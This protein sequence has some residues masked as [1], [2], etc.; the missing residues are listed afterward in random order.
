[1]LRATTD[2]RLTVPCIDAVCVNVSRT[3]CSRA[4]DRS[5]SHRPP[6]THPQDERV[7]CHVLFVPAPPTLPPAT[8]A[9]AFQ[10][11]PPL[12]PFRHQPREQPKSPPRLNPVEREQLPPTT[13]AVVGTVLVFPR[14][15]KISR[16]LTDREPPQTAE[17]IHGGCAKRAGCSARTRHA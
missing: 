3:R 15:S 16:Q 11:T 14:G 6:R 7:C 12:A 13:E 1:M 2:D 5:P 4:P 8:L 9:L 17:T 10:K